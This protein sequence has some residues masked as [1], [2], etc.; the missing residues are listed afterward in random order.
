MLAR[1]DQVRT[2]RCER[3]LFDSP[4]SIIVYANDTD[5]NK[6]ALCTV[7]TYPTQKHVI[8]WFSSINIS[9]NCKQ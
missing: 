7:Y 1:R 4:E 5:L 8:L 9:I 2:A 6:F 3:V